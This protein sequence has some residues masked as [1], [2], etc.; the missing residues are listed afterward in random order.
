MCYRLVKYTLILELFILQQ[1]Y[2]TNNLIFATNFKSH[3]V[4]ISNA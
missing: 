4:I 1:L 3:Y 2:D